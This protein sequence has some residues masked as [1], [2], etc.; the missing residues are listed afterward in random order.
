MID[1]LTLEQGDGWGNAPVQHA[2][3]DQFLRRQR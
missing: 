3:A 1:F 2:S